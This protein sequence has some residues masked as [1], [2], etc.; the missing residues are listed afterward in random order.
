MPHEG[1]LAHETPLPMRAPLEELLPGN[2]YRTSAPNTLPSHRSLQSAGRRPEDF[3]G[4]ARWLLSSAS[5]ASGFRCSRRRAL[6]K[7]KIRMTPQ[8]RA[9][10]F[11][12]V[13]SMSSDISRLVGRAE[14]APLPI[15]PV[16]PGKT[17]RRAGTGS[18]RRHADCV[19][20]PRR[21]GASRRLASR[22]FSAHH[23]RGGLSGV[24]GAW[25]RRPQTFQLAS[26]GALR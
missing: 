6:S 5:T 20:T 25:S 8:G 1:P 14:G 9:C 19:R 12:P 24:H 13:R 2:P 7:T 3:S 18:R 21:T 4:F 23:L 22:R 26:K 10:G 17:Y 11:R 15:G 16:L